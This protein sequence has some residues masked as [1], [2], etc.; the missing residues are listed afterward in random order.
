LSDV[1]QEEKEV[2]QL[3]AGDFTGLADAYSKYRPGYSDLVVSALIGSLGAPFSGARVADIGAG[4]GIF[5][6]QLL[7][8]NPASIVAVEP[9][10]DMFEVG[11]AGSRPNLRWLL[12]SAESTGLEASSIDLVTMASSFH[13]PNTQQALREFDRVLAPKGVFAA[14]W[15]PRI[16]ERSE[17][18]SSIDRLLESEYGVSTRVS[19]GRSVFANE[20]EETLRESGL[21]GEVS[22][23][24]S[25]DVKRVK[26]S[27][28]I[29]A[30]TSVNDIQSQLGAE[31]FREFILQITEMLENVEDVDVH[32]LTR[33]W[34]AKKP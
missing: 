1:S 27:D 25:L 29:G 14:L 30:W 20:L 17:V 18:E 23:M 12:G 24:H 16:T 33:C 2:L 26:T 4:T 32:Y 8:R 28:Y 22:Y 13:W 15:N 19:S 9:N 21:F 10:E 6:R 7:D 5:S 3:K 31:R 11:S 34:I